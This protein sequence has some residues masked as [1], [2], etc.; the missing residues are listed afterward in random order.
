MADG[1]LGWGRSWQQ[2]E[3]ARF[4]YE[5]RGDCEEEAH[6]DPDIDFTV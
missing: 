3:A 1:D 4:G 5:G 6:V 2:R